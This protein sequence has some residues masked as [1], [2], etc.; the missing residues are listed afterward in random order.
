QE[1]AAA[2]HPALLPEV[3]MLGLAPRVFL[4]PVGGPLDHARAQAVDPEVAL[5]AV[6]LVFRAPGVR[7]PSGGI[8]TR[9]ALPLGLPGQPLLPPGRV[10]R[11]VPPVHADDGVLGL[12]AFPVERD[13]ILIGRL[14]LEAGG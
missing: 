10:A 3:G 2:D 4:E 13:V 7:P 8:E 6:L 1:H 14:L 12:L 11:R 9:R 5:A